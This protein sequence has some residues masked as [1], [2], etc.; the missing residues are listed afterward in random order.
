MK[1]DIVEKPLS[2]EDHIKHDLVKLRRETGDHYSKSF[3]NDNEKY[4]FCK[5]TKIFVTSL[6]PYTDKEIV[7]QIMQ[8]YIEL[9]TV[10]K[11]IKDNHNLDDKTKQANILN[12]EFEYSEPIY[13]M[14]LRIF[15]RSPVVEMEAQGV[16]Q[17]RDKDIKNRVRDTK[18]KLDMFLE[19]D[20]ELDAEFQD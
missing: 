8:H 2:P 4:A 6:E 3:K 10:I 5:K 13:F 15:H 18:S 1:K 17:S 12:V 7:K 19:R 16:L 20:S 14:S 9:N 11:N